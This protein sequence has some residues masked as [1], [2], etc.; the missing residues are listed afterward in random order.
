MW[1]LCFP[2][3]FFASLVIAAFALPHGC[4]TLVLHVFESF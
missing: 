4:S 2:M 1:Q 3:G